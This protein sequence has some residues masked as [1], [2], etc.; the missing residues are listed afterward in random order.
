MMLQARRGT[1]RGCRR[2][3]PSGSAAA[4]TSAT[5]RSTARPPSGA[6]PDQNHARCHGGRS[7]G[8]MPL[9]RTLYRFMKAAGT[10]TCGLAGW[11]GCGKIAVRVSSPALPGHDPGLRLAGA[12]GPQPGV[13]GRRD[14]GAPPRGHGAPPSGH[15]ARAGLGRP[16]G[17]G[18]TG[19]AASVRAAHPPAGHAGHAAGLAPPADHA[20]MDVPEPARSSA[21]Q[22][23]H[24]RPGIAAGGGEPN[25]GYRRVHGE[26]CRLGHRISEA[27]VRRILRARRGSPA[28]PGVDTSWRVFLRIQAR[29]C[30]PA[31]SSRS[32]RSSSGALMY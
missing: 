25:W 22:P 20:Q 5:R 15:P 30:L 6:R 10:V 1:P 17:P 7:P 32:T 11:A 31:I 4:G 29:G 24:P 12:A 9:S 23:G 3:S 19:P 26:L 18:G 28:P 16:G 14:H 13:Q 27:T 2:G 8:V 21:D